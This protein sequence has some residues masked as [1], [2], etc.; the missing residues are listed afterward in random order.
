M[1]EPFP[2]T[3]RKLPC[4]AIIIPHAFP[5]VECTNVFP[6]TASHGRMRRI[7]R[8]GLAYSSHLSFAKPGAYT[9][10]YSLGS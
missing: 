9:P 8:H 3:Q 5:A 4:R 1:Y 7:M 10:R 2:I 6:V